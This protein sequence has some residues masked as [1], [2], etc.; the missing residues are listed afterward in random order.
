MFELRMV[1]HCS[2]AVFP[3]RHFGT[4]SWTCLSL[5]GTLQWWLSSIFPS[6]SCQE[7]IWKITSVHITDLG[8]SAEMF[9][10]ITRVTSPSANHSSAKKTPKKSGQK[11]RWFSN[12]KENQPM[13]PSRLQWHLDYAQE[14]EKTRV[15]CNWS[16]WK[17][18][19]KQAQMQPLSSLVY[20]RVCHPGKY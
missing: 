8:H 14:K 11:G 7:D 1:T 6:W 9:F 19:M 15:L 16:F 20:W 12:R 18:K 13:E 4:L 3:T 10:W 17:R 2:S 5:E